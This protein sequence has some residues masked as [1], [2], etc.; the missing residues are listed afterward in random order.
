MLVGGAVRD[1][2]LGDAVELRGALGRRFAILTDDEDVHLAAELPS[3]GQRLGG[4]VFDR[5][6]VVLSEKKRGHV[7]EPPL[8]SSV[9]TQARRPSRPSRRTC[10]L[11]AL[12][13]S[14]PSAAARRRRR[15]RRVSS[16]RSASSSP[17]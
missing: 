14:P 2:P 9:L 4:G 17:S 13:S 7:R 11:G 8:R 6:V 5:L 12:L 16:P 3:G 15:N 10:G 1:G